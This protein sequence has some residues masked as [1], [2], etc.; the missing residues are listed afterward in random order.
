MNDIINN[1]TPAL[2]VSECI[3]MNGG[4]TWETVILYENEEGYLIGEL[5]GD[6]SLVL[7]FDKEQIETIVNYF[8]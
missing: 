1:I 8:K 7:N 2:I 6:S 4:E 5:R 3:T